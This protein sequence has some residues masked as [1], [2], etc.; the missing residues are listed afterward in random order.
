MFSEFSF[1]LDHFLPRLET[2][3]QCGKCPHFQRL[4]PV[5]LNSSMQHA[6]TLL[7][8]LVFVTSRFESQSWHYSEIPA[9]RLTRTSYHNEEVTS[10]PTPSP[11][12]D[13]PSATTQRLGGLALVYIMLL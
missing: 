9:G 6:A 5:P 12:D 1:V 8:Q 10:A 2:L 11:L 4:Q 3:T 13:G 7:H